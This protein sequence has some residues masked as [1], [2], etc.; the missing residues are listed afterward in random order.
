MREVII[1]CC[2]FGHA[3]IEQLGLC[4]LACVR[5]DDFFLQKELGRAA[6]G[7]ASSANYEQCLVPLGN[8]CFDAALLYRIIFRSSRQC[9]PPLSNNDAASSESSLVKHRPEKRPAFQL[10]SRV[11]L[12]WSR[13]VANHRPLCIQRRNKMVKWH[14]YSLECSLLMTKNI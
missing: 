9:V 7:I 12:E 10:A 11:K 6:V 8:C 14:K 5:S 1:H 13:V 2:F 3:R 4:K